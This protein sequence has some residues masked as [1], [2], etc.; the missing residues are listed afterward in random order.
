M[1]MLKMTGEIGKEKHHHHHH[2]QKRGGL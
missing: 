2:H 1:M